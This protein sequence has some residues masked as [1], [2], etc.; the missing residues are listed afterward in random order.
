MPDSILRKTARGAGWAIGWRLLTRL[1]G[2][3]S[4]LILARL[5][6]PGDFGLVALA[7]GF[8]QG[9][10]AFSSLGMDE[11][12][13]RQRLATREVYDTAFTINLIRG[14]GTALIVA[15]CAWPVAGFF[16]D[17]RLAPVLLALA[18]CA[19]ITA[20]ENIGTI[21]FRRDFVFDK[22]FKLLLLPRLAGILTTITAAALWR[23]HWALIAGIATGQVLETGMGYVMHP[24][25]P[26]LTLRAWRSLAAFSFWSWAIGIAIMARDRVDGFV[27]GRALGLAR[28]GVYTAGAEIALLPTH[29]LAGPLSRACFSGFVAALRAETAIAATYLRILATIGLITLPIAAGVSLVAAPAVMLAFGPAWME[30]VPVVR[31]LGYTGVALV[32]GMVTST[33]LSAQGELRPG[34]AITIG[35]MAVRMVS[36]I[37]LV[38]PLGLT[39]VAIAHALTLVV[40]NLAYLAVAFRRFAIRPAAL[41]PL[42]GRPVL[43]TLAMI[44]VLTLSGL[45]ADVEAPAWSLCLAAAT[46]A[47]VYGGVLLGLWLVC[48]GPEGA[49]RDVLALAWRLAGRGK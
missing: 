29:E 44:A 19:L 16:H 43:A 3:G 11:A 46:G 6:V 15:A 23:S 39:G 47:T 42:L 25:R 38:G 12:V 14:L 36:A 20:F 18:A 8:A 31:V 48:G 4:M 10:A 26:R 5:L 40:E 30:A 24:H 49:E 2:F 32:L 33:L 7:T 9:I 35:S 28:V 45:G 13:I 22:E 17:P 21:E 37:A 1:L 41:V 34:L 27:I